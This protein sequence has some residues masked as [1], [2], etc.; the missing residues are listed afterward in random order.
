V[1]KV[2][3]QGKVAGKGSKQHLL[4]N[5]ETRRCRMLWALS[6]KRAFAPGLNN[7]QPFR[8]FLAGTRQQQ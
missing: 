2:V 7:K 1:T 3:K 8:P 4:Y 5:V 6:A